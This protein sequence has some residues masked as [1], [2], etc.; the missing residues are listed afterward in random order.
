MEDSIHLL[1]VFI[2]LFSTFC[3]ELYKQKK[4]HLNYSRICIGSLSNNIYKCNACLHI[5]AH[6]SM[7]LSSSSF[8]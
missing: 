1:S 6:L 5:Y 4:K 2:N 8:I 3:L 7:Y